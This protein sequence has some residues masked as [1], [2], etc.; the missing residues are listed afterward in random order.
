MIEFELENLSVKISRD[1]LE[2]LK[3]F[4]QDPIFEMIAAAASELDVEAYVIGGFVRDAILKKPCK[5]VAII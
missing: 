2:N 4:I 3:K 1:V 5:D